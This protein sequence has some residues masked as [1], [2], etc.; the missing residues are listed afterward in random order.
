MATKPPVLYPK[1][2]HAIVHP[3]DYPEWEKL[4]EVLARHCRE[5]KFDVAVWEVANEPDIGES[6]GTPYLFKTQDYVT[7]YTHTVAGLLRGNAQAKVGGPTVASAH[8]GL[9]DA[10]IE[11]C[12]QRN[13]PLDVLSWHLYSDSPAAHVENVKRMREKLARFPQLKNTKTFISEWNMD[14][15]HPNLAPQFQ[16]AFVLETVHRLSEAGLD[17]AA[18]YHVRDCFVDDADFDWMSPGGRNFM[19]HWWNTMP[20]YGAL[21]DHHGRVRPAWYAFRLLGQFE[22]PR[23]AVA[24]EQ[25]AIRAIACQREHRRHVLVW[26]YEGG[27]PAE[28]EVRLALGGLTGGVVRVV[29]LDAAAAVNTLKVLRFQTVPDMAHQPIVLKLRPWEIR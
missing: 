3:T 24:G 12:A 23:F 7:Y 18:Y 10:L 11:H 28:R 20:Q 19:A 29:A 1:V 14:L 4:C 21:F 13:V 22:G 17:M 9:V 5:E 8:S 2:D 27:G 26:R 16:P 25:G 15:T 6:G